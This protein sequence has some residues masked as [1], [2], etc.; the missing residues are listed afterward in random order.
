MRGGR[1][2][3]LPWADS[4]TDP[5]AGRNLVRYGWPAPRVPARGGGRTAQAF[6]EALEWAVERAEP[7]ARSPTPGPGPEAT[8]VGTPIGAGVAPPA[9]RPLEPARSYAEVFK[10]GAVRRLERVN[11]KRARRNGVGM[12]PHDA[13]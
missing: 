7:L 6:R 9:D 1:L 10:A 12:R 5:G 4:S 11:G 13:L 8:A 3:C 2:Q